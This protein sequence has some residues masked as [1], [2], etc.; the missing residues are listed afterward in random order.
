MTKM[1]ST[2]HRTLIFTCKNV[3]PHCR[4]GST[5][6]PVY[7]LDNTIVS[8][9]CQR[10]NKWQIYFIASMTHGDDFMLIGVIPYYIAQH[11]LKTHGWLASTWHKLWTIGT[12]SGWLGVRPGHGCICSW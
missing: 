11:I 8:I 10:V 6:F 1:S 2:E 3:A 7:I 4:I 5:T 9:I 12:S